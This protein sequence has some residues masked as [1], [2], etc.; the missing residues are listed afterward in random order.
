M[1]LL[2]SI[3]D[4]AEAVEKDD[5]PVTVRLVP[6]PRLPEMIPFPFNVRP[7]AVIPAVVRDLVMFNDPAKEEEPVPEK[8]AFESPTRFPVRSKL[9]DRDAPVSVIL[10]LSAPP[11]VKPRVL[12]P[13]LYIPV[14]RSLVK[15]REGLDAV[16]SASWRVPPTSK[17]PEV[18][19]VL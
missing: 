1:R 19:A 13:I 16:P 8:E 12:V 7:V 14:S 4:E 9:P 10:S 15:V 6:M 18:D 5:W 17:L 2:A 11:V 3:V